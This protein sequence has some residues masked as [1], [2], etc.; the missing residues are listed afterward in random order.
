MTDKL[1]PCPFCGG[2]DFLED[3]GNAA[4]SIGQKGRMYWH[5]VI[6]KNCNGRIDNCDGDLR[7]NGSPLVAKDIAHKKWNTR[8]ERTCRMETDE[9][10]Q[11]WN[12]CS[13]C[14]ADYY[15]DQPL[16]YCPNCGAR[17]VS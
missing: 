12:S 4:E 9:S 2:E 8:A 17:V 1:L 15:T 7:Y 11:N 13:E 16:N 10:C 6:C 5:R 3:C 14:D